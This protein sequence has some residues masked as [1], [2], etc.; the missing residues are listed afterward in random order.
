[1]GSIDLFYAGLEEE[2]VYPPKTAKIFIAA[3]ITI[4]S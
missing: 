3:K 1:M 2:P 4:L